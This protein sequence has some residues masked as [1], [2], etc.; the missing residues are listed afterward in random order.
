MISCTFTSDWYVEIT[1]KLH[2]THPWPTRTCE[3]IAWS[4]ILT[5]RRIAPCKNRDDAGRQFFSFRYSFCASFLIVKEHINI[6]NPILQNAATP[7]DLIEEKLLL[8]AT[9]NLQS[10]MAVTGSDTLIQE[11]LVVDL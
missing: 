2:R 3:R 9:R 7:F 5:T 4:P 11:K 1:A 6:L 10:D 8:K